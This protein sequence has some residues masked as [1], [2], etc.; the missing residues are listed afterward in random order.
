[1]R[2]GDGVSE[3][4]KKKPKIPPIPPPSR[5]DRLSDVELFE[6]M[7]SSLG[8]VFNLMGEYRNSGEEREMIMALIELHLET[9][10]GSC[11]SMRRRLGVAR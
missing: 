2:S 9:A 11:R 6:A 1:V 10:L 5:L 8:E 7:E 3:V 4:L